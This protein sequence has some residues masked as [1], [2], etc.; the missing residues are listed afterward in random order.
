MQN[1]VVKVLRRHDCH[2]SR[3]NVHSTNV[4]GLL[5][6]RAEDHNVTIR[7]C[8]SIPRTRYIST[9]FVDRVQRSHQRVGEIRI[10]HDMPIVSVPQ[11]GVIR[12][13]QT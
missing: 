12:T 4:L 3:L 7:D 1:C 5:A 13:G 8:K 10:N 11:S 2:A 9:R 6:A